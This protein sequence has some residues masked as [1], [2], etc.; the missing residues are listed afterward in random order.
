MS[1]ESQSELC[2]KSGGSRN[3]VADIVSDNILSYRIV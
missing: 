2:G 1:T 3:S